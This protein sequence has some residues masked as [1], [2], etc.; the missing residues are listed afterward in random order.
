M[1]RTAILLV[2]L[3]TA[4]FTI[5]AQPPQ[6][7]KYKAI[8]R[9]KYGRLLVNQQVAMRISILQGSET[10]IAV[11]VE[12]HTPY[13]NT[14]GIIDLDIG[15]GTPELGTMAAI[16]W[17]ASDYF[18]KIEMDP[19]CKPKK[20]YTVIGTSQ[21]LSVPYALYAGHV[22]NSGDNDADPLNELITSSYLSGTT[23]TLQEGLNTILIDLSGL[24]EGIE[25]DDADP[26]NEIQ[27]LQ[28]VDNKLII[29]KNGTAAEIDLGVFL[30]NTDNQQLT[31]TGQELAIQNGN[32]VILPDKVNDADADPTNEIQAISIT[33]HELT[34]AEGNTITL[35]DE[36][37]DADH[38]P[39][40][41]L[42]M[43]SIGHDTIYLRGGGFVK[44]PATITTGG[45]YYYLDKDGDGYGNRFV[46]V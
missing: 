10:G 2:M 5:T 43:L 42:Q 19:K 6:A 38:D 4:A 28:L 41:E 22:Q 9:D 40:N 8:A 26:E 45:Q 35:P 18:I 16:D 21:L 20:E 1:K 7:F 44:M 27:D 37:N 34:I 17:G 3:L 31:L 32:T 29:T 25:D 23:L 36:V 24:L 13:S 30:D 15:R 39:G 14:F 11:Y 33:G 46:P 12:T